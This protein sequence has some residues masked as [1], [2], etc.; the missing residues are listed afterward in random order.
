MLGDIDALLGHIN[1]LGLDHAY[2]PN[3]FFVL[4]E[5]EAVPMVR[6]GILGALRFGGRLHDRSSRLDTVSL[7]PLASS[8]WNTMVLLAVAVA[9][10]AAALGYVGYLLLSARLG[11]AEVAFLEAMGLSRL[12]LTALLVFEHLA[13]VFVALGLGTWAGF[14]MSSLTVSPLA[15]TAGGK[16]VVPPFLL[17][18]DWTL[19]APVYAALAVILV[20]A[21]LVLTRKSGRLDL[22]AI[23]RLGEP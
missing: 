15:V 8:G 4:V 16:P 13:I 23:A 22:Q 1:V 18:T 11:R 7:D 19:M 17:V 9:L 3:E 10:L 14:R 12:Q 5:P 2:R 6:D 21:L 20:S